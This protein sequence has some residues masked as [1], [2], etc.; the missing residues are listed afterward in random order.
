LLGSLAFV[1]AD[2]VKDDNVAG[3][4]CRHKLSLDPCFED[5]AVDRLIDNPWRGQGASPS[6]AK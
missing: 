4:Q 5:A 2:I 6:M 1:E 3:R